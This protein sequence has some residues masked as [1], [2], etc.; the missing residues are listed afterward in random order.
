M[1]WKD[2]AAAPR[3]LRLSCVSSP[4]KVGTAGQAIGHASTGNCMGIGATDA[5]LAAPGPFTASSKL[6]DYS[7]DGPRKITTMS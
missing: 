1:I 6:E 5:S 2:G 4:L 3:Y 7:S